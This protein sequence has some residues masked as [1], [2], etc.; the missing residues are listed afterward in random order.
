M[1]VKEIHEALDNVVND[2]FS[3]TH[4]WQASSGLN[5]EIKKIKDAIS[6]LERGKQ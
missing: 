2:Y 3:D 4:D 5:T 1:T 6:R